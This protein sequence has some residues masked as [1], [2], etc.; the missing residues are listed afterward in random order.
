M[1]TAFPPNAITAVP[2]K[3]RETSDAMVQR[4]AMF[5]HRNLNS[6]ARTGSPVPLHRPTC[7]QRHIV[8]ATTL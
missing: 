1:L 6:E 2:L 8:D 3:C 4:A 7:R 5:V